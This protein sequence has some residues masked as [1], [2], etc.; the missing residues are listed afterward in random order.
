MRSLIHS[1]SHSSSNPSIH[2][3]IYPLIH[4][5]VHSFIHSFDRSFI[6]AYTVP[7][8]V[9]VSHGRVVSLRRTFIEETLPGFI[10]QTNEHGPDAEAVVRP[11]VVPG[12]SCVARPI[13]ECICNV[14][15][16]LYSATGERKH[17]HGVSGF[18]HLNESVTVAKN[19]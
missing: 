1:F 5:F 16:H 11:V 19:E 17:A 18:K 14:I 8:F 13:R 7:E 4:S 15:E 3:S 6:H 12:A 9:P 10:R 2:L